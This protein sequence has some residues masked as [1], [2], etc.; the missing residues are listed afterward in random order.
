MRGPFSD[1]GQF[2]QFNFFFG[3]DDDIDNGVVLLLLLLLLLLGIG[4][5]ETEEGGGLGVVLAVLWV[6]VNDGG[7][8]GGTAERE[9]WGVWTW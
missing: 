7:D 4:E 3:W 2:E 1:E 8:S 5:V 9:E 6:V